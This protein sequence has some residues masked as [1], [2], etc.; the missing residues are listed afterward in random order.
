MTP[1]QIVGLALLAVV[2]AL[3]WRSHRRPAPPPAPPPEPAGL[4]DLMAKLDAPHSRASTIHMGRMLLDQFATSRDVALVVIAVEPDCTHCHSSASV[5]HLL[6]AANIVLET[7]ATNPR[8]HEA[9]ALRA[10]HCQQALGFPRTT[11]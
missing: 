1:E 2:V 8:T 9:T 7:I 11:A 5:D 6:R 3:Y 10:R 4:V